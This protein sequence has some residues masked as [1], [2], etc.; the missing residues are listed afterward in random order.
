MTLQDHSKVVRESKRR[1][2]IEAEAK[3]MEKPKLKKNVR[4]TTNKKQQT[5][6]IQPNILFENVIKLI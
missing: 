5:N 1:K 6:C 4:K 3:L 2:K